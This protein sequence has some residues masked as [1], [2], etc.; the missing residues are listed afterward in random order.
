MDE[1]QIPPFGRRKLIIHNGRHKGGNGGKRTGRN[2][3]GKNESVHHIIP[4]SR[5]DE[6]FLGE[7]Y[8]EEE[9]VTFYPQTF[10]DAL[11][12]VFGNLV[13]NNGEA[14]EFLRAISEP[15]VRWTNK[16]L[17]RL[18]TAIKKGEYED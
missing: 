6:H 7:E 18:R 15:G 2:G 13:P 14:S 10:G 17:E 4:S 5:I 8:K 3:K 1:S 16:R 12:T 11:H 9:N